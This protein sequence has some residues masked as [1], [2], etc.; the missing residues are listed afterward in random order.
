MGKP[1]QGRLALFSEHNVHLVMTGTAAEDLTPTA[2]EIWHLWSLGRGA[3]RFWGTWGHHEGRHVSMSLKRVGRGTRVLPGR[4]WQIAELH[5]TPT[6]SN[7]EPRAQLVQIPRPAR[8]Q[9]AWA[10]SVLAGNP[11]RR[12]GAAP[13]SNPSSL[14]PQGLMP[15]DSPHA[16]TVP[17]QEQRVAVGG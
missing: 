13:H 1:E 17:H 11:E 9:P 6:P 7:A 10:A 5:P 16:L 14:R 4:G 8:P 3:L 12:K 15:P 2:S